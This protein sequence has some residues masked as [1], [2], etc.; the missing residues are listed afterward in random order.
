MP[1]HTTERVKQILSWYQSDNPGTLANLHRML[2]S[3]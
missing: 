3:G 2:M 1:E